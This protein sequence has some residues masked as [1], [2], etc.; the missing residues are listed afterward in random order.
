MPESPRHSCAP[1]GEA[2][3]R[4]VTHTSAMSLTEYEREREARVARNKAMLHSTVTAKLPVAAGPAPPQRRR[5]AKAPRGTTDVARRSHRLGGMT[6]PSYAEAGRSA[7][8]A[9]RR[10]AG[11]PRTVVPDG[12]KPTLEEVEAMTPE[13]LAKARV[14]APAERGRCCGRPCFAWALTTPLPLCS[15]FAVGG[16]INSGKGRRAQVCGHPSCTGHTAA[17]CPAAGRPANWG[18]KSGAALRCNN[19]MRRP[20]RIA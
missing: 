9:P 10:L 1:P 15:Q 7:E 11:A 18:P 12:S 20:L 17:E 19:Q 6:L 5:T 2:P 4:G 16:G 14:S 13:E 8:R 3:A